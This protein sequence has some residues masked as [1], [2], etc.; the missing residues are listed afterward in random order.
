MSAAAAIS[1]QHVSHRYGSRT[2]VDDLSPRDRRGRSLRLPRPQRQRQDDAV[3]R[4]CRR[5]S[6][7]RA[8]TIAILATTSRR[9]ATAVR[10][11]IGVVFQAASLDKKLT[12]AEN[13]RHQGRLYGLSSAELTVAHGGAA[14]RRRP[15][16]PRA[17]TASKRS[18]A[19]CVAASSSPSACCTARGC[20]CSTS[21]ARASTPAPASTCGSTSRQLRERDGVTIVLTTHL[22]DEADRADRIAIM[23]QGRLAALGEPLALRAEVGGDAI[24]IQTERPDEL[25]AAIARA[26]RRAGRGR[27]TAPCGSSSPTATS[28]SRGWSRRFPATSKPSRSASRRSKTSSS[29]APAIASLATTENENHEDT[30]ARRKNADQAIAMHRSCRRAVM[31]NPE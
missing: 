6:R 20:C 27:S 15:R 1:V 16:G 26:V 10:R 28:G 17:T 11:Q 18:P 5:S 24:T 12:V 2:A 14:R 23:H 22:L 21:R 25:A 4:C 29:P 13:L 3:P 9:D 19:A 8:A 31:V 30:K 7:C